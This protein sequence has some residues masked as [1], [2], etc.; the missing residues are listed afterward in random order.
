VKLQLTQDVEGIGKAGDVISVTAA[1][2]NWLIGQSCCSVVDIHE[3]HADDPPP[4]PDGM[5][6]P[7]SETEKPR[8]K[9]SRVDS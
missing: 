3:P 4:G 1:R 5:M 7:P 9:R 6:I 8:G 2:G